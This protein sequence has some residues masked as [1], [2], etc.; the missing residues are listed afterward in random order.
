MLPD[1]ILRHAERVDEELRLT[2]EFL[3]KH[4]VNHACGLPV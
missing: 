1:W 2:H 3:V 4:E